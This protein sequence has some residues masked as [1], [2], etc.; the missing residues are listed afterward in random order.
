MKEGSRVLVGRSN[1][2][3]GQLSTW[4]KC[5]NPF[6]FCPVNTQTRQNSAQNIYTCSLCL[7]GQQG[8][9]DHTHTGQ[10]S[11]KTRTLWAVFT[12]SCKMAWIRQTSKHRFPCWGNSGSC[13]DKQQKGKEEQ[14][15]TKG[16]ER[17]KRV[18]SHIHMQYT[19]WLIKG[20]AESRSEG[21]SARGQLTTIT[22]T[23]T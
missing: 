21:E 9:R 2:R 3:K 1:S 22:W 8:P 17:H 11:K 5:L 16:Q 6:K 7:H 19:E 23:Q 13:R 14:K 20:K 18:W 12:G 10:L 15:M 4:Q